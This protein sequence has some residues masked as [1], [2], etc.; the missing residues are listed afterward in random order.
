M[1]GKHFDRIKEGKRWE[2]RE[3]NSPVH[4]QLSG[5]GCN[6]TVLE[7]R[8]GYSGRSIYAKILKVEIFLTRRRISKDILSEGHISREEI[9]EVCPNDAPIVGDN[10][11][12]GAR[13]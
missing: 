8:R 11:N 7:L 13:E 4:R 3:F 5:W 9:A 6:D 12:I 10:F 2:F 1:M